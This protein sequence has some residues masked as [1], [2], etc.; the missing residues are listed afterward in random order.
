MKKKPVT[1][2]PLWN[3]WRNIVQ[4]LSDYNMPDS[5]RAKQR[6]LKCDWTN[7]RDFADDVEAK[8]G[9]PKRGEELVRKDFLRGWHLNNLTYAKPKVKGSRL[10]HTIKL[11]YKGKTYCAKHLAEKVGVNYH[12]FRNRL[13]RG[14]TVKEAV[15]P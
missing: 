13:K 8:L 3:K 9:L 1:Q 14:W 4:C 11:R 5:H 6:G 7:F 12:T 15:I 10:V 2:H